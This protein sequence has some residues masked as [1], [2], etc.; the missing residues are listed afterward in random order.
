MARPRPDRLVLAGLDDAPEVHDR[1][2]AGDAADDAEVVRD[3]EDPE[4]AL[5][6][7]VEQQ[8]ED[9]RAD[10]HVHRGHRLI[11]DEDLGLERERPRDRRA[12]ELAARQRVRQP[13]HRRRL[14][15]HRSEQGADLGPAV[16]PDEAVLAQRDLERAADRAARVERRERV[17]ED[18]LDT[19]A[20]GQRDPCRAGR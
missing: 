15:A 4:V 17:L 1:D 16:V 13:I 10:R 8:V 20:V 6:P 3:E 2:A 18:E 14:Q 7:Q 9:L 12:L 5:T 19:A 11:A